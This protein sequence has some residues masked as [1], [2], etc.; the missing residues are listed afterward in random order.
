MI[1]ADTEPVTVT[2]NYPD[3]QLGVG[4]LDAGSDSGRTAMNSMKTE[5]IHI[6]GKAR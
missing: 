6:V 3:I 2:G 5:G 1:T 4:E